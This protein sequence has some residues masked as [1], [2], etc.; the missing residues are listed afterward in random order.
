MLPMPY[1]NLSFEAVV[2][3]CRESPGGDRIVTFLAADSGLVE[4]F[5]FGGPKS[6]LRSL[7][8]PYHAGTA[9]I[10]RDPVKDLRKLSDFDARETYPT[11]RENLRKIWA[12]SY[13]AETVLRT[14]AAGGESRAAYN[15]LRSG[16]SA[17]DA[18][19][20]SEVDYVC[21]Q[22]GWRLLELMGLRPDPHAC[23][24][25]GTPFPEGRGAMFPRAQGAFRCDRCTRA[26]DSVNSMDD[27]PLS[28][29]AL[30][31]LAAAEALSFRDALRV[32]PSGE[33]L[34]ILK[35][36]VFHLVRS[37]AEGELRTLDRGELL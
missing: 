6:K 31:Y 7:A 18:G 27:L 12:A 24:Q 28:G 22:Y 20:E 8:A 14:D 33:D 2:L 9:W 11:L 30:R 1:R 36:L 10:Y 15:L 4:A 26:G 5:V 23:G 21:L 3:R 37:A 29:G 17:L 13:F 34:P 25:C 19:V 32:R 35:A 16:L